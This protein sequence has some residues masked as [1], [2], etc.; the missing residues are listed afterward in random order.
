MKPEAIFFLGPWYWRKIAGEWQPANPEDPSAAGGI[1]TANPGDVSILYEPEGLGHERI[2]GWYRSRGEFCESLRNRER[3]PI[4]ER[5]AYA[6]AFDS[7]HPESALAAETFV[8][9]EAR[10]RLG[11]WVARSRQAGLNL[12]GGWS[13]M[14]LCLAI[15]RSPRRLDSGTVILVACRDFIGV[16]TYDPDRAPCSFKAWAGPQ[17]E[18][19]WRS[20]LAWLREVRAAPECP[21][22]E[23]QPPMH[24]MVYA[25]GEVLKSS[26]RLPAWEKAPEEVSLLGFDE[27]AAE[28]ARLKKGHTSN[29]I[30]SFPRPISLV[31][32]M[33]VGVVAGCVLLLISGTLDLRWFSARADRL[34]D[35]AKISESL[36]FQEE[37]LL[38]NR[39]TIEGLPKPPG[40]SSAVAIDA[41]EKLA[42][43]LPV[44]LC[45][46]S[47][48]LET[49]GLARIAGLCPFGRFPAQDLGRAFQTAGLMDTQ[50]SAKPGSEEWSATGQIPGGIHGH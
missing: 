22:G 45:L 3:F 33:W 25:H 49:T 9:T 47:I 2:P 19:T 44:E 37:H 10:P 43:A 40:V 26:G 36:R 21:A 16:G 23:T 48:N 39:R 32:A 7:T 41:L 18:Q 17:T 35:Q 1:L 8:H 13:L 12:V 29:L 38:A 11:G 31:R 30:Q 34:R 24:L 14:S 6:W 4:L 20:V 28:L 42:S 46:K 15:G 50:V 27:L 5:A